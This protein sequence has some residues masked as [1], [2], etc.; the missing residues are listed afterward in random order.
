MKPKVIVLLIFLFLM[1]LTPF[2]L[3]QE[4]T[5]KS[6]KY[7]FEL[8]FGFGSF[9]PADVY[10]RNSGIDALLDQYVNYYG[11]SYTFSGKF[12]QSKFFMPINVSVNYQLKEKIFLKAGIDFVT[13]SSSSNKVFQVTWDNSNESH[14]YYI[15]NRISYVMPHVGVGY[16]VKKFD[17]Y[18]AL[19]LAFASLSRTETLDYSSSGY[20]HDIEDT[21]SGSGSGLGLIVGAKYWF[22]VKKIIKSKLFKKIKTFIKAELAIL[23]VGTVTG[24]KSRIA[25]NSAGDSS[26]QT[27]D[28]TFYRYLWNPYGKTGFEY[29]DVSGTLPADPSI[30]GV[31]KLSLNLSGFRFMIGVS[32]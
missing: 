4:E 15:K 22:D 11:A 16:K 13:N 26:S 10:S 25:T 3:A 6:K 32:F 24:S 23:K 31:E 29:W 27:I 14:D 17:L 18:G 12:S 28:G 20:G 8:A 1:I 21:F 2:V 30:S 5:H 9:N 7:S 19:G